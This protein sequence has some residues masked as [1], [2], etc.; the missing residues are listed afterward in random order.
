M[1]LGGV[2]L[3]R[4]AEILSGGQATRAA[5]AA[6][7]VAEPDFIL[8]DEPT[9]NLDAEG[10]TAVAALLERWRGG[11]LAVSH[12]RALLRRMDRIVELTSLGAVIY[13]GNYDLYAARKAEAEAAAQHSLDHAEQAL[14][15]TERG[16]QATRERKAKADA[17][18]RRS[19]AR[20]DM[21]GLMLN[22][23][24]ERAENTGAGLSRLGGRLRAEAEQDLADAHAR[25]ERV[26][27]LAFDLPQSGL[28]GA[29]LALAF[30]GCRLRLGGRDARCCGTSAS[31]WVG[32]E[33]LA[34]T[35]PNGSARRR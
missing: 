31:G 8:M 27:R 16:I 7:L 30:E 19:R 4:P 25:I 2:A 23:R 3:D 32:P 14:A 10:R 13:G 17:A 21:P 9:N 11:A 28:P 33:R 12:D 20:N 26:R 5:L 6:L 22:A 18:G 34:V 24:A 29:K 35:G 1:G 15:R